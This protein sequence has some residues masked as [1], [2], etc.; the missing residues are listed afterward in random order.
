[1]KINN[2][3][4]KSKEDIENTLGERENHL[5][6]KDSEEKGSQIPYKLRGFGGGDPKS[7]WES[8]VTTH[9]RDGM[10]KGS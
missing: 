6:L 7:P 2:R 3:S 9:T 1:M 8:P 4:K 10:E 5:W